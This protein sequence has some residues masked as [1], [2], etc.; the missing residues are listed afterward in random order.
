MVEAESPPASLPSNARSA[1]S[2]SG[3]GALE[4]EHRDQHLEAFRP[5]RVGRQNRRRKANA[6]GALAAAVARGQRTASGPKPVMISRSGRYP[7]RTSRWRPSSISF[8]AWELSKA[9]TSASTACVSSARA[10]N[11]GQRINKSSW[12]AELENVNVGHGVSLL[13]WRSGGSNN[14]TIR[15]LTSSCRHQLSPI[16]PLNG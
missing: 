11:L 3:G 15:R 7:W 4:V 13:R 6:L 16:A 1:S 2:K 10:P 12:L 9:A 14:P 5:A 8:S